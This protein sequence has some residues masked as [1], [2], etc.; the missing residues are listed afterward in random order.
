MTD[1]V[2]EIFFRK[3][4]SKSKNHK[5]KKRNNY[6]YN[7]S[8]N[9]GYYYA[10]ARGWHTGIYNNWNRCEKET[11]N[12]PNPVFRKFRS[13]RQAGA[14]IHKHKRRNKPQK[15]KSLKHINYTPLK[16]VKSIPTNITCNVALLGYKPNKSY[17]AFA[18]SINHNKDKK[19]N[20]S[21]AKVTMDN[22][23]R[24][25]LKAL[26]HFL[27]D[28][29]GNKR[30]H[31]LIRTNNQYLINIFTRKSWLA[32][33]IKNGFLKTDGQKVKNADLLEDIARRLA[34]FPNILFVYTTPDRKL[35]DLAK[36][37]IKSKID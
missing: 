25:A 21:L 8:S 2:D 30:K 9:N 4:S 5:R 27:K 14:F 29:K 6:G 35:M 26:D 11:L 15:L 36:E 32:T 20:R 1:Y 13:K 12:Y 22:T 28:Y 33:W 37:A 17:G 16:V 34:D 7:S 19:N 18:Y 31:I 10:V 23:P 3:S 24:L